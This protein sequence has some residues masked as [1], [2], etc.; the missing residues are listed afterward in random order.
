MTNC[1]CMQLCQFN[2]FTLSQRSPSNRYRRNIATRTQLHGCDVTGNDEKWQHDKEERNSRRVRLSFIG[3]LQCTERNRFM[4]IVADDHMRLLSLTS[5][6]TI[7]GDFDAT[8]FALAQPTG[9]SNFFRIERWIIYLFVI[10]QLHICGALSAR[11]SLR[12]R[13]AH[14]CA[15]GASNMISENLCGKRFEIIYAESW[16]WS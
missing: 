5:T 15:C 9:Q 16:S 4:W 12:F 13:I 14:Q 7:N 6:C 11:A 10:L 2:I 8:S 1:R 3:E